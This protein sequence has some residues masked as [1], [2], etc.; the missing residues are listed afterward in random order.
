MTLSRFELNVVKSLREVKAVIN[1][2]KMAL[3]IIISSEVFVFKLIFNQN[4]VIF[5]II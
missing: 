1:E 2:I 4:V 3:F 5:S